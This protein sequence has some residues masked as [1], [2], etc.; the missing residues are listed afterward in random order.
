MKIIP[1]LLIIAFLPS[2]YTKNQA[3]KKF[4]IQDTASTLVT[5][6]DTIIIDSSSVD[7]MFNDNIDSIFVIKNKIQIKYIKIGGK[8]E[9]AG[10]YLG[11]TFYKITTIKVKS[12]C[13]TKKL[14][15]WEQF[16]LDY[17]LAMF[18]AI[19]ILLILFVFLIKSK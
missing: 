17:G 4:C 16:C 8:I 14:S 1:I 18:L 6:Y 7:T 11:D 9:L 10:K 13:V 12:P 5:I 15:W 3:L 2:C 19:L